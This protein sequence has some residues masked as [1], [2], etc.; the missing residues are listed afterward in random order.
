[1]IHKCLICKREVYKTTIL[2]DKII[3]HGICDKS[4]CMKAYIVKTYPNWSNEQVEE[5][6]RIIK[7]EKQ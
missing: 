5:E 6:L 7:K 1:M 2:N 4:E 3:S